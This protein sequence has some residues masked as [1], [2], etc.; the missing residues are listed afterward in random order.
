MLFR[1]ARTG[2]IIEDILDNLNRA[3]LVIAD[4]TDK[5]PNVFYELGVRHALRHATI[6]ISQRL[7]DIP[8][9]LRPLAIH[10]YDW[11]TKEGRREFRLRIKELLSAIDAG[12]DDCVSPVRK[13]L[14]L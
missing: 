7:E 5:N 1:S 11:K 9:D 14:R 12:A 3:D 4:L 6:L 2:N 8:F 10:V 13:Y